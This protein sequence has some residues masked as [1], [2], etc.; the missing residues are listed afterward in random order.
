[1]NTHNPKIE[2]DN[3]GI[4]IRMKNCKNVYENG[5]CRIINCPFAHIF[6]ELNPKK[7]RCRNPKSCIYQHNESI[8]QWV[9]RIGL[10]ITMLLPIYI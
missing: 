6:E 7:C 10:D 1:M 4:Q 8:E 9:N 3:R 5:V 2:F